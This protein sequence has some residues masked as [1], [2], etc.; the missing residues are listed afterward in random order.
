MQ[1]TI[2]FLLAP[3]CY[4]RSGSNIDYDCLHLLVQIDCCVMVLV[5]GNACVLE[6]ARVI[7]AQDICADLLLA[8][9]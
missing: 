3:K 5:V 7:F 8:N 4:N 9:S 1:S 6:L 2:D